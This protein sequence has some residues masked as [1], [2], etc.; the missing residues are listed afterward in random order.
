MMIFFSNMKKINHLIEHLKISKNQEKYYLSDSVLKIYPSKIELVKIER[1]KEPKLPDI[2]LLG[3]IFVNFGP[4]KIFQKN[5][6]NI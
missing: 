4:L 3:L 5:S 1:K 2:V 6:T